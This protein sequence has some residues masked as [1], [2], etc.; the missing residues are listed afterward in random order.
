MLKMLQKTETSSPRVL[1]LATK[2]TGTN[3]E[4]RLRVLLGGID[5]EFLPFDKSSKRQSFF[6]TLDRVLRDRPEL[7]VMEG[8]GLAGGLVCLIT[9]LLGR[10]RYVFSSGDAVGPFIGAHSALAGPV[11]SIYER[12]LCRLS[13]GFIGWTPYLSGRA[14]TFGAPRAVTACGFAPVPLDAQAA[15]AA[16]GEVR[17]ELGIDQN[18]IVFGI[19]GAVMWNPRR[20]Y[21]Y[22]QELIEAAKLLNREDVKIL[23]VGGGSG[24]DRLKKQAGERGGKS[25]FFTGMVPGLEVSRYLAAMDI[26]SLPQSRDGVGNFRYTTK[27]SEYA[28]AR[29]PIVTGR[30]PLAYD[31]DDGSIWRLPGHAPWSGEFTS[32]LGELMNNISAAE[33]TA[34]RAKVNADRPEFDAGRQTARV[35]AFIEDILAELRPAG[36]GGHVVARQGEGDFKG[37]TTLSSARK[38]NQPSPL[39]TQRERDSAHAWPATQ[40]V[41]AA[42]GGSLS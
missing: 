9:R 30:L 8:T 18:A 15:E 22:G 2:G 26:A 5:A 40:T 20:G 19:A 39:L 34:A 32:A 25:I 41:T 29:L 42:E 7:L 13:A 14:L 12:L 17:R 37:K 3:E 36:S 23:I 6:S 4:D 21:C 35:T 16:R 38:L 1:A 31:L 24:L 10:S 11:F 28:A 27:I 33:L